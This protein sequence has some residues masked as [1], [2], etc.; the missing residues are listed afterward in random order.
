MLI[1]DLHDYYFQTIKLRIGIQPPQI[2]LC[3]FVLVCAVGIIVCAAAIFEKL[4]I[5]L[6]PVMSLS[7]PHQCLNHTEM[8]SFCHAFPQLD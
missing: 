4:N 2:S 8:I 5:V 6:L 3:L 1:L 7:P